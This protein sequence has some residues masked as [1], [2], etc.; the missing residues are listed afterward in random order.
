M[1]SINRDRFYFKWRKFLQETSYAEFAFGPRRRPKAWTTLAKRRLNWMRLF[2]RPVFFFFFSCFST[3][4]VCPLTLPARANDPCTL[5]PSNGMVK[6]N[7]TLPK[8]ETGQS[9]AK[10][11]P[12]HERVKSASEAFSRRANLAWN[13]KNRSVKS[14]F[15]WMFSLVSWELQMSGLT[16]RTKPIELGESSWIKA[17]VVAVFRRIYR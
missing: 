12:S 5:P 10:M 3:F 11:N 9:L 1:F 7:S 15:R 6:S 16:F 2:A 8:A 14:G 13:G 4:G 17:F